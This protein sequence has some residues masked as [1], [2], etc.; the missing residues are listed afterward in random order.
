MGSI[1]LLIDAGAEL[2]AHG[3]NG[4]TPMRRAAREGHQEVIKLIKH[5]GADIKAADKDGKKVVILSLKSST[6]DRER[7]LEVVVSDKVEV[8]TQTSD[9]QIPLILTDD[10]CDLKVIEILLKAGADPHKVNNKQ[11]KALNIA[12]SIIHS[13]T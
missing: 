2:E 12:F 11:E 10:S 4:S 6:L 8:L 13:Q 5:F 3:S 9:R 1:N 7:K